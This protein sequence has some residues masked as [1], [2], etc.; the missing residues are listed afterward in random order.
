MIHAGGSPWTIP[1]LD[2]QIPKAARRIVGMD[3]AFCF[4]R[5]QSRPHRR[6][7]AMTFAAHG[8]ASGS[9]MPNIF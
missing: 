9:P 1:L 6:P 5:G 7:V 8:I 4:S 3:G 2:A